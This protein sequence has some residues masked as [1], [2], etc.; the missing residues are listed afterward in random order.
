MDGTKDSDDITKLGD[1]DYLIELDGVKYRGSNS[2]WAKYPSGRELSSYMGEMGV[3]DALEEIFQREIW[4]ELDIK[5][6][7]LAEKKDP[8]AP[9]FGG[10]WGLK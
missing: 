3:A 5:Y 6:G 4:R 1:Y 9:D 2:S 7:K 8:L 10:S